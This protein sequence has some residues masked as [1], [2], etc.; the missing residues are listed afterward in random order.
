MDFI[1]L[2]L[3]YFLVFLLF[4]KYI[5]EL[6]EDSHL[7]E[8]YFTSLGLDFFGDKTKIIRI[9]TLRLDKII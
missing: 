2:Y 6:E 7:W 8:Y 3:F 9:L 4:Y 1:Y 5:L